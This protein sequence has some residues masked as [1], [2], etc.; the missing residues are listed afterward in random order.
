MF[1]SSR[2]KLIAIGCSFT[3]H[4][5]TSSQSPLGDFDFIRW[6]QH[7]ADMLDMECVNLGRSG[8]GNDQILARTLDATLKEKDIGLVVIMWSE[9]QRIGFQRFR[10]WDMWHQVTPHMRD[11]EYSSKLFELQNPSHATRNAL[12]TFIHAEKILRDVPYMFTQGTHSI[13][14]YNVETS[15]VID[16]SPGTPHENDNFYK[17]NDSRTLSAKVMF[18][19]NDYFHY[20][21][22]NIG[23]KFI[24]WPI[25][26]ELGGYCISDI[27]EREDPSRTKLRISQDDSHPNASGHKFIADF[28]YDKYKEIHNDY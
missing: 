22:N 26:R 24:G 21:E 18:S 17:L 7:L 23:D 9:W 3:H 12:R 8:A 11:Q 4:Y 28:L 25:I 10:N 19:C 14:H 20:I 6:P 5:L 16:C 1:K 13:T 15:K 2:K 27:L